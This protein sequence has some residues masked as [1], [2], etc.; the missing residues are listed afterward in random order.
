[1][2]G[3]RSATALRETQRIVARAGT[4]VHEVRIGEALVDAITL[5]VAARSPEPAATASTG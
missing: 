3:P 5:P 1:M 4:A 2:D